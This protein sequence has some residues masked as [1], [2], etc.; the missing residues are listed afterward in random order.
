MQSLDIQSF[1]YADRDA[2][3]PRLNTAFA[4][5][6]AWML[7]RRTLSPTAIE[8]RIEIQLR[9]IVDVYAAIVSSGLELTRSGHL[10]L[11]DLWSCRRNL[12]S[13]AELGQV[14]SIRL[15]VSFLDHMTLQS[16]LMTGCTLA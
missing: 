2:L 10:A 14:I 5:C 3:L 6:G 16:L 11:T 9:S 15:E 7:G 4:E 12:A 13:A 8:F 1:S